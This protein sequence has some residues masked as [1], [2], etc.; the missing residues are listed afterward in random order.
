MGNANEPL[1]DGLTTGQTV[2][3]DHHQFKLTE[4]LKS[5][6]FGQVWNAEDLT[7]STSVPVTLH[8]FNPTMLKYQGF[9]EATKK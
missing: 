8:I 2:G 7:T 5:D 3:P 6:Q 9:V 1:Y 4:Q